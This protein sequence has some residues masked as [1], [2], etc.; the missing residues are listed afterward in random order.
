MPLL[1]ALTYMFAPMASLTVVGYLAGAE[2]PHEE[3]ALWSTD[4]GGWQLTHR[5]L[6]ES[7]C[8]PR[9]Y[10]VDVDG[11]ALAAGETESRHLVPGEIYRLRVA[12]PVA[13]T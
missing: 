11:R 6:V 7:R 12:E 3:V 8:T 1:S 10:V 2:D 9:R 13:A 5:F 4:F